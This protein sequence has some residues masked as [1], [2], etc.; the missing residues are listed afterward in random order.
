M[1]NERPV[2][3]MLSKKEGFR[4]VDRV[5]PSLRLATSRG[6]PRP[7]ALEEW[8]SRAAVLPPLREQHYSLMTVVVVVG[9]GAAAHPFHVRVRGRGTARRLR[10]VVVG[11]VSTS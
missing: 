1:E 6:A 9:G 8:A 5:L 3:T 2:S 7:A 10:G 4:G 11:V